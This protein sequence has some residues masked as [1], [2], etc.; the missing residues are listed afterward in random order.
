VFVDLAWARKVI[1]HIVQN[2]DLYSAP[3]EPI[4]IRAEEKDGFVVF[5]VT[6]RGPG[7]EEPEI[8]E[9]FDRFYRGKNQRHRIPGTGMGLP[10]AKAIVEAHGGTIQVT[11]RKGEGSVFS[12]TFPIDG[13]RGGHE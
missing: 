8:S 11:S 1:A 10:I 9:I 5:S 2:A 13:E 12:F 6:D 4:T 7:I 3:G